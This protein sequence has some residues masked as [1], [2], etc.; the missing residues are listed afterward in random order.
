MQ[1]IRFLQALDQ[2]E[3]GLSPHTDAEMRAIM[4]NEDAP[5]FTV[6]AKTGW[7]VVGEQNNGW[8]VGY[9]TRFGEGTLYFATNVE[10]GEGFDMAQF[11]RVRKSV[12]MEALRQ[13]GWI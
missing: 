1:Q 2:R 10:P 6:Y 12:T 13:K 9:V 3:L 11:A 5:D 7:S 4:I 8:F